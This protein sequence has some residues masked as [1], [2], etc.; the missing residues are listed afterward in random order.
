MDLSLRRLKMLRELHRRGT[1]TAA[2]ESL[3]Y[4]PSGISQQ[5]TQLERDVGVVLVE[6]V[7]R[8]VRLTELGL[9]LAEHA[10][11]IL[12]AVERASM[13]LEQV[14][15]GVTA[16]LTAGVWASVAS[17][18]VTP[19]LGALAK[20]H[21]G[22]EVRTVELAPE[23]MAEA[24]LDGT[25]DFSFVIDYTNYPMV[26]DP[27]LSREVI[28]VERLYAAAPA[29]SIPGATVSLTD[30]SEH[31]WILAGSRSHLGKAIRLAC[32]RQGFEPQIMHTVEEQ[33]TALV[34]V[35]GGLGVSLVSDLALDMVPDGVGIVALDQPVMRTVSIAWRST[36]T[37]RAPLDLVVDAMRTA[38]AE[39][40]IAS[41][42][43][44]PQPE[45]EQH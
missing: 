43:G 14:Q 3:H 32:R 19:A 9:V 6:R 24:V 38:A 4:S 17:G 34:M 35:A 2:A 8:R 31:P 45:E 30:L 23:S 40:G 1:V 18:L 36:P 27:A 39:R 41:S 11:E 29:G 33:S 25:L 15:G 13:A 28:A 20:Q 22:I 10:E 37:P 42:T 26:W 5:L 16:R 44:L 12:G 21:P 7:G